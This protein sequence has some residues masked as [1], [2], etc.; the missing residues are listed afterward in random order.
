ML[1][2]SYCYVLQAMTDNITLSPVH[3]RALHNQ[4]ISEDGPGAVLRDFAALLDFVGAR[5]IVVSG[6]HQLLPMS[7]LAELNS[8]LSITNQISLKRPQQK[9]YPYINGLY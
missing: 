1:S 9:S 4:L 7:L 6:K 8:R 2:A 3:R 5:E